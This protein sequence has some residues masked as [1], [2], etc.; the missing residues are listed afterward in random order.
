MTQMK[1][2]T[3]QVNGG[4]AKAAMFAYRWTLGTESQKN[5]KGKW[6]GWTIERGPQV[7][8]LEIIQE[9]RG[10]REAVAQNRITFDR[11]QQESSTDENAL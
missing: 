9:A 10:T 5:D 3:V 6:F 8:T 2:A 4:N 1:Q 11:T 7:N